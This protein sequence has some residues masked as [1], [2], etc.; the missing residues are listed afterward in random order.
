MSSP[1]P[2]ATLHLEVHQKAAQQLLERGQ[3]V[4]SK[5][6]GNF[7]RGIMAFKSL[8]EAQQKTLQGI[9][10]KVAASKRS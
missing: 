3:G 1:V 7:L 5:F 8:S 9:R 6:E 2:D 4:I 10:L